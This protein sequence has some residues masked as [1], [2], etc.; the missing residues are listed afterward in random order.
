MFS[1]EKY[2]IVVNEVSENAK[3][4]GKIKI[5]ADN[6]DEEETDIVD[7]LDQIGKKIGA[8]KN[9]ETDYDKVYVTILKDLRDVYLGK[10]T[11]DRL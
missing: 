6:Y 7:I 11:F 9:G 10:V 8:I 3:T 4:Q 5:K 1:N 2:E